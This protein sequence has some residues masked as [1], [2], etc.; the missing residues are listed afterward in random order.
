[1]PAFEEAKVKEEVVNINNGTITS[2]L[3]IT[4]NAKASMYT[5]KKTIPSHPINLA[6][7]SPV[8]IMLTS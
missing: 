7:L 1:L 6:I 4:F 2:T 5:G 3:G 8:M